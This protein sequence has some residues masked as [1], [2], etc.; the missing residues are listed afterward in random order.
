MSD[1]TVESTYRWWVLTCGCLLIAGAVGWAAFHPPI[2]APQ[3]AA[4]LRL[5]LTDWAVA[6]SSM[7]LGLFLFFLLGG[8]LADRFGA[9]RCA[10]LGAVA[11][12]G[13]LWQRGYVSRLSGLQVNLFASGAALA[14][15]LVAAP[16]AVRRWFPPRE[17]GMALS[18]IFAALSFGLGTGMW[19]TPKLLPLC[20]DWRQVSRLLGALTV[21]VAALWLLSVRGAAKGRYCRSLQEEIGGLARL[22]QRRENAL[23]ALAAA[24]WEGADNS[25]VAYLPLYLAGRKALAPAA[26]GRCLIVLCWS[27]VPGSLAIPRM[28]ARFGR[29]SVF[30]LAAV[31]WA[32]AL[33]WLERASGTWG[34]V[35]TLSLA[36]FANAASTLIY[37]NALEG[38]DV[39]RGA[40]VLAAM[41]MAVYLGSLVSPLIGMAMAEDVQ[42]VAGFAYWSLCSLAA[43]LVFGAARA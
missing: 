1:G 19:L 12:G 35:F 39:S 28:A 30:V 2:L 6:W 37:V 33:L 26:V 11:I 27:Y 38:N 22:F 36:G 13:L 16:A 34:I 23:L 4:D 10:G 41:S 5:G 43:A 7:R 29:R 20:G 32:C 14:L 18:T 42:P 8:V 3:I 15:T 25:V 31:A 24:L 21:G 40:V 17:L 9:T